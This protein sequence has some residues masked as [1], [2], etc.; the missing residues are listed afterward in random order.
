[1]IFVGQGI[2][3]LQEAGKIP[4]NPIPIPSVEILGI[5]P[6]VESITLQCLVILFALALLIYQRK[7][8]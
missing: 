4:S 6:N 8:D 2:A 5:Y 1:V 3:A 7:R